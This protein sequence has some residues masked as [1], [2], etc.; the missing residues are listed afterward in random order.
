M[1]HISTRC[2]SSVVNRGQM[3][4]CDCHVN[5]VLQS[6]MWGTVV[7]AARVMSH[8]RRLKVSY[9]LSWITGG[10][11]NLRRLKDT[12]R[13]VLKYS[14]SVSTWPERDQGE[15]ILPR[16]CWHLSACFDWC[17]IC[18]PF[19]LE[20]QFQFHFLCWQISSAQTRQQWISCEG[21]CLDHSARNVSHSL[22]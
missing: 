4:R 17:P 2:H 16:R 7:I 9:D 22:C 11:N 18:L 5:N 12:P 3:G 15:E 21:V 6:I 10:P 14:F 13:C 8:G 20:A 1:P 19:L